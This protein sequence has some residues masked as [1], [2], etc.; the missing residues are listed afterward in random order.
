MDDKIY[1]KNV[2]NENTC[3]NTCKNIYGK[4]DP[5]RTIPTCIHGY[6]FTDYEKV[7]K[8]IEILEAYYI[9]NTIVGE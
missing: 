7:V 3:K 1:N 5:P 4:N 9:L 2:F 8:T 6:Y